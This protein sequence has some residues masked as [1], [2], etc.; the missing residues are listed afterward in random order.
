M[1]F[2]TDGFYVVS[3]LKFKNQKL[4]AVALVTH[5]ETFAGYAS[6]SKNCYGQELCSS[7]VLLTVD[8][9]AALSLPRR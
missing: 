1:Q 2:H 4:S 8:L 7:E 6:G 3:V 5:E 9:A